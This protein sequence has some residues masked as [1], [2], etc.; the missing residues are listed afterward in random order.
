M[1]KLRAHKDRFSSLVYR[2]GKQSNAVAKRQYL[3]WRSEQVPPIP[4][5]CDEVECRLHSEP[6]VWN[7]SPLP[8]ILE[9]R[10][11]VNSDNRPKNLRLLCPNCDSQNR[12]TRGGANARRVQ[13]SPGGFALVDKKGKNLSVNSKLSIRAVASAVSERTD[14]SQANRVV[15]GF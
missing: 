4:E 3:Q 1:P 6:L 2:G 15:G 7:G 12:D 8:L 14:G 11:G 13:K 9:H 10:N 5:Q